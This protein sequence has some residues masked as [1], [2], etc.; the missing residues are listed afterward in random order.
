[1][2]PSG[3]IWGAAGVARMG[4]VQSS[5]TE[6]NCGWN[7]PLPG[8]RSYSAWT[9][10]EG[11]RAIWKAADKVSAGGAPPSGVVAAKKR[12]HG[13]PSPAVPPPEL[14]QVARRFAIVLIFR[15]GAVDPAGR[16]GPGMLAVAVSI[17][18][19]TIERAETS[20]ALSDEPIAEGDFRYGDS[21]QSE[22]T[23]VTSL[24]FNGVAEVSLPQG[25]S[26]DI[27][28]MDELEVPLVRLGLPPVASKY[29]SAEAEGQ[30]YSSVMENEPVGSEDAG[31]VRR[32]VEAVPVVPIA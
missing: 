31:L 15:T 1:M 8:A 30:V 22:P 17:N 9:F 20:C 14:T 12:P 25:P 32:G 11:F 23:V 26:A 2:P 29:T 6:V 27:R 7:G 4:K 24:I 28:I 18:C 5:G 13:V 19:V 10:L 3:E 21:G 16:S